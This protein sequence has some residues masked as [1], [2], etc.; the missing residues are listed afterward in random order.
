MRT[1]RVGNCSG[2]YGD[3]LTAMR[4][5][6][7]GGPLDYLTGDYLA[8]LT[9]LILGRDRQKNPDTGYAK[10]FLRQVA[11]CLSLARARHVRIVA[12]AGGVNPG[13]LA[14][15]IRAL[16]PTVRVAHV[17]G[18]DLLTGAFPGALTANAYLGAFG[19]AEALR[20]GAD[21]VVTGRVTDA[22]LTLGPAIAAFGWRRDEY[23]KLAAGIVA[24][25]IL[26][27]GTQATGGNFSGFATIDTSRPLGFPIAEIDDDGAVVITKHPGT[28]GAVTEDTVT[29]QLVY[30]IDSPRYLN[31]DVTA[32]LDTIRLA[33]PEKDRVAICGV[34]GEAPPATT[35]IGITR[36]GGYRNTVSFVL[37]GLDIEAKAAW[38]RE[39]F[40][41]GLGRRPE[42][43]VWD[44]IRTDRPDP[45]TQ[46]EGAAVLH[47]HGKDADPDV[48]GRPFSGAAIELAL[49]SYPGFHVTGPPSGATPYGVFEAAY[50][51]QGEVPHVVVL[52]DGV[53]VEVAAPGWERA[54]VSAGSGRPGRVVSADGVHAG[55][56]A[57]ERGDVVHTGGLSTGDPHDRGVGDDTGS[58]M[59]PLG[60]R[61]V[62]DGGQRSHPTTTEPPNHPAPDG[63][64]HHTRAPLGHLLHA[65]SGDKAGTANLGIWIPA[66]HP[67]R[68]AAFRWLTRWLTADRLRTLLPESTP[69]PISLHPLPNLCALNI[70]IAGL[71]GDGVAASTR[72]D[73]QAKALGEWL[74][75]R[76]ADIPTELL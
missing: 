25:H 15:A 63:Y 45:G 74:R 8:E 4:E 22:S 76:L 10:T 52:P 31:P 64:R 62:V 41:S 57:S 13:A 33:A 12:N 17:A 61:A 56:P 30:E 3:R 40:E 24:G 27:C 75:S 53:R 65:R 47:C 71:L 5:M 26:E 42:T 38:V 59:V 39:Q 69:F 32:R 43:L 66:A 54:G 21:I 35:K 55:P 60:G 34:R 18:D 1:I 72:P 73:P 14:G 7:E 20:S 2:F 68:L 16:D 58:G 50:L 37:T 44:L 36:L 51:P 49:A 28:G 19:I 29:A 9:M 67:H 11:D 70:V 6:L 48:V 46:A 23:D